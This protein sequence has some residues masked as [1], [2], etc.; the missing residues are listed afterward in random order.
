[1]AA[2]VEMSIVC[3]NM[4]IRAKVN[5]HSRQH[6]NDL[7]YNVGIDYTNR[8]Q[9]YIDITLDDAKCNPLS[10]ITRWIESAQG[11]HIAYKQRA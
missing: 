2:K 8:E 4:R 11:S 1:M 3:G 10:Q 9:S 5:T 6:L 7:L